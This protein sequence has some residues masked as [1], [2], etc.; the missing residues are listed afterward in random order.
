MECNCQFRGSHEDAWQR[1]GVDTEGEGL[2]VPRPFC[3]TA[4]RAVVAS[5]TSPRTDERPQ[6][7]RTTDLAI[8]RVDVGLG[9][10]SKDE[11]YMKA[12]KQEW[13]DLGD[14]DKAQAS[15]DDSDADLHFTDRG[16]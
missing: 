7:A 1:E 11:E 5:Q 9:I 14:S 4:V 15:G 12:P 2:Q 6:G 8:Q 3:Q 13:K 10:T 16:N